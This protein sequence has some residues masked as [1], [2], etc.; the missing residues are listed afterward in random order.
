[1]SP[2]G[3]DHYLVVGRLTDW[4][5]DNWQRKPFMIRVQAPLLIP[6]NNS[7]PEPDIAVVTRKRYT[8]HPLPEDVQL[9][10]EISDSSVATDIGD[11]LSLY[12]EGDIK[13]Y[14][15]VNIPSRVIHVYHSPR[16]GAYQDV[17]TYRGE[18]PITSLVNPTAIATAAGIFSVLD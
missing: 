14:W 6:P 17:A 13:D 7:A 12:A 15:V 16:D 10:V 5:Y 3:N 11:K 8:R 18:E 2:I 9:L 4:C 1:M